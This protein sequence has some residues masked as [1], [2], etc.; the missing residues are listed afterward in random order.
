MAHPIHITVI[1]GPLT[2]NLASLLPNVVDE[3]DF[4]FKQLI[5]VQGDGQHSIVL[6]LFEAELRTGRV[7]Q[8]T[9]TSDHE[10]NSKSCE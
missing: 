1:R 10:G 6:G 4:A 9:R 7:A 5:P 8:R 2:R 3:I